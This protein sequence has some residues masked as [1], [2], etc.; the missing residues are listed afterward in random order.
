MSRLWRDQIQIFFA[1]DRVDMVRTFRG[2]KSRQS[3]RISRVHACHQ[4]DDMWKVSLQQLE[5][6]IEKENA[7]SA[8]KGAEMTVTLSNH[9]VRY[10]VVPP[11]QEITDPA[12]LLAYASFRMREVYGE[13][14]DNWLI[15][16][17]DWDLYCGALSAAIT[18]DLYLELEALISRYRMKLKQLEPYLTTAFDQWCKS[19]NDKRFWFVVIESGRL[20]MALFSDGKWQG[21][22]NQRLVHSIE[23]EL[24]DSL[25]QEA[26][27]SGFRGAIEQVYLFSPEHPD[28]D[29]PADK[30][31]QIANLPTE[32]IPV[33]AHFPSP[34]LDSSEA[35][36][37]V[38]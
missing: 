16:V 10:V 9:F 6:M 2:I 26:I 7:S 13:R 32:K 35:G 20:C 18:R 37:C 22:R 5:Q 34:I 8:L 30:G 11:Q 36:P 3:P 31:W 4:N 17:S 28:L 33:P 19:F 23:A 15:S 12:E 25:E 27:N 21:I 24:L 1:P 14:V 38:A 29:L